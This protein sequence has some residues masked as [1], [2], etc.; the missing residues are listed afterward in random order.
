MQCCSF[1]IH[2]WIGLILLFLELSYQH[3]IIVS[4]DTQLQPNSSIQIC[5]K[6]EYH[7]STISWLDYIYDGTPTILLQSHPCNCHPKEIPR[8]NL[9]WL[10][11]TALSNAWDRYTEHLKVSQ[12]VCKVPNKVPGPLHSLLGLSLLRSKLHWILVWYG[13]ASSICFIQECSF[14]SGP[15]VGIGWIV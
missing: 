7:A 4:L 9:S 2:T 14:S 15:T 10:G 3:F 5:S 1:V 13:L 11:S 12:I 8:F 6:L